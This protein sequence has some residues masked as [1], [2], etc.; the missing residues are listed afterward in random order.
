MAGDYGWINA[1]DKE[2]VSLNDALR[3]K[4]AGKAEIVQAD[5]CDWW[6]QDDSRIAGAVKLAEES[7]LAIVAVGTRSLWLGRSA[8][9]H[10]VTS[11]EGFDISSLD[12][13]GRQ[14][15]LLKAVKATGKPMIVVLITGKPLVMSWV[16][17]NA[18][19]IICQF[20]AGEQQG[21]ALA[22]IL[23]GDVNPSGRLN[24]S[25]PRST[26]NTPCYYNYYTS[27]REQVFDKGGS[28]SDPEGHYI[29]ERPYALWNFGRGLSYTTF[30]YGEPRFSADTFGPDDTLTVEV[31]VTNTGNRDGKETVQLYV[32]DVIS[33]VSTP[34]R[35]L[36]A[37]SKQNIPA[38]ETRT[39]TLTLPMQELRLYNIDRKYVVEPGDFEI[40]IGAASDDIKSTK[41]I[42]VK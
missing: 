8:K 26:G 2:C 22:D 27:D 31:D 34:D 24:I 37:F 20:Y 42:T 7:A 29:F 23:L 16:K 1:W 13:P 11:G 30:E 9:D 10:N 4:L 17:D 41:T 33:S 15:D 18:D 28:L 14:L 6:S 19:A 32:R 40:Q 25:F 35:M 12:L 38:G 3:S 21:N 5:G 39:F 36:R